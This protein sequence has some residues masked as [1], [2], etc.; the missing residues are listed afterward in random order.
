VKK[1]RKI[2]VHISKSRNLSMILS[3][4][5]APVVLKQI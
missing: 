4:G 3:Y 2:L 5:H 1:E